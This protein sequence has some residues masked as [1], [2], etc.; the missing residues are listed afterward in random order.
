MSKNKITWNKCA[1]ILVGQEAVSTDFGI[2]RVALT[3]RESEN[4]RKSEKKKQEVSRISFVL[5]SYML[6]NAPIM[7]RFFNKIINF[8]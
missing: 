8:Y 1:Y 4:T 7:N 6:E 3:L 5:Y 2:W